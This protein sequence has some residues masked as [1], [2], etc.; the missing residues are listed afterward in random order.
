MGNELQKYR[1]S[2]LPDLLDKISRNSIGL[3]NYLDQFFNIPSSNY[4]PYNLIHLS[5]HESKLEIALAGF[6]KDEVKVFTEYGK[7]TVEGTKP[8]AEE[9]TTY[10]HRGLASRNFAKSWTLSEDCEVSDVSFEDG[11]LVV[12]LKKIIPE[13]HAR[14][15]Y[16]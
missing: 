6:K 8:A 12:D 9:D 4:P 3:D 15:D 14:K 1:S 7:L 16:I 11:L 13:K 2:D 10:L 5:N